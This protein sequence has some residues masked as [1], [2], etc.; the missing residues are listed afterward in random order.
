MLSLNEKEKKL[1]IIRLGILLT[2]MGFFSDLKKK[3][4]RFNRR[5]GSN[6]WPHTIKRK[7]K[8]EIEENSV[9]FRLETI[10]DVDKI[11]E[12]HEKELQMNDPESSETQDKLPLTEFV[13]IRDSEKRKPEIPS[14][15]TDV[16]L[17]NV[18][19]EISGN[20]DFAEVEF[21]DQIP[22]NDESNQVFDHDLD[23]LTLGGEDKKSQKSFMGLGRIKINNKTSNEKHIETK[24]VE[25]D[26]NG[27]T[28]TKMELE[29]TKKEIE[30]RQRALEEIKKLEK[31]KE[32]ELKK[33]E[34][35]K[36]KE[37]RLKQLELKKQM[38]EKKLQ[39]RQEEKSRKQREKELKKLDLKKLKEEKLREQELKRLEQQRL[40]EEKLR[41]LQEEKL[42]KQKE[43]ELK[44][45][46]KIKKEEEER[47]KKLKEEEMKKLEAERE[48]ME[49]AREQEMRIKEMEEKLKLQKLESEKIEEI[50][51]EEPPELDKFIQV[52]KVKK[53]GKSS[54]DNDVEKLLLILDGLLE[55]LPD[56][57][58]NEFAESE[59]F[60]IYERVMS[61]YKHK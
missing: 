29:R 15:P 26:V 44:K 58:I 1:G 60:A 20:Q 25:K 28:M 33:Q 5:T 37:E 53:D 31:Q 40:K 13:E 34:E 36:K 16:G 7:E 14:F 55:K 47:L 61:K 56:D 11:L 39:E 43:E 6:P 52:E 57:V 8:N 4:I 10:K 21:P 9:D 48:I 32:D 27:Y 46:E 42:K 24:K 35:I 3:K 17:R 59:D 50:K 54:V 41:M 38:K 18:N 12:E 2:E 49:K 30:E 51:K 23:N 45:L 19:G 22:Q